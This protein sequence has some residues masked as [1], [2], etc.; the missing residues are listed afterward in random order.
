MAA[1][2][3]KDRGLELTFSLPSDSAVHILGDFTNL[4]RLLW[5]LVDNAMKYTPAQGR[6]DVSLT[7]LAVSATLAVRDTGLGI[8]PLDLPHVF[9]RFYR[10]D[11]SRSMVER[12]GLGLAIAKWIAEIHNAQVTVSSALDSG[13][14]FLVAFPTLLRES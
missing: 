9:D 12:N 6:V 7:V 2:I 13:T 4:R 5:I 1:P 14:T 3:A 10:T 8:S 11:P